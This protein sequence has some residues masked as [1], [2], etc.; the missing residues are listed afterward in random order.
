MSIEALAMAGADYMECAIDLEVLECSR[1]LENSPPY[2]LA[3]QSSII[4][5]DQFKLRH[6]RKCTGDQHVLRPVV[7]RDQM[8]ARIREWAKAVV[9]KIDNIS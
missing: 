5:S 1:R 4:R 7:D 8:K 2:L 9:S 6:K 3:E